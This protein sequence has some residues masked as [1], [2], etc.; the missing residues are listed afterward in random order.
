VCQN[1][2]LARQRFATRTPRAVVVGLDQASRAEL[3]FLTWLRRQRRMPVLV[4]VPPEAER[5]VRQSSGTGTDIAVR[6]AAF[7]RQ[8][9]AHIA[10]WLR[11]RLRDALLNSGGPPAPRQDDESAVSI[12]RSS[13]VQRVEATARTQSGCSPVICIGIS[14]GGPDS[15]EFVFGR[16]PADVPPIVIVQH[17]PRA[18]TAPLAERLNRIS[19]VQVAEAQDGQELHRGQAWIA[20]GDRHVRLVR[21]GARVITELDDSPPV[22]RHRPSVNVLFESAALAVGSA[23][24]ALIMTGMGDD[25]VRG[26]LA[27]RHAGAVTLAQD[28]D[29]SAVFGMP[30]RAIL[31]G[32]A[33]YVV[34]LADIPQR[35]LDAA[36]ARALPLTAA[37]EPTR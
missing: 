31:A 26:M 27:L 34:S 22:D 18:Y 29:S 6:T 21:H 19:A 5:I 35:L 20:P 17:M 36:R 24:I 16:L 15:L 8:H 1:F 3:E 23:A 7:D 25:G 33:E 12:R 30:Q 32:A 10:A 2:E 14:T 9:C 28:A 4:S 13:S 11:E 37:E